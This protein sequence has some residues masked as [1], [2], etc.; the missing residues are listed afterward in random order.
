MRNDQTLLRRYQDNLNVC[1]LGVIILG[2]WGVLKFIMQLIME[3]RDMFDLEAANEE[4]MGIIIG[5]TIAVIAVMMLII[6]LIFGIYI[7]IGW[8]ASRAARDLP[9]KRGYFVWA[10]ILLVLSAASM[11]FYA[12]DLKDVENIDSTI[13]SILVDLTGIY[14]LW[15][16]IVTTKKIRQLQS[17]QEQE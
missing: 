7:Y 11:I 4:E 12:D 3:W 8:N 2:A 16:V 17:A 15:N 6:F 9:C 10:V 14:I 1:G 5:V 13:A